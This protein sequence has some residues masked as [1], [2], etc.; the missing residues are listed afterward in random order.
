MFPLIKGC[1]QEF[2]QTEKKALKQII[3]EVK[4]TGQP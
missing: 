3:V 2:L 4:I 1:K